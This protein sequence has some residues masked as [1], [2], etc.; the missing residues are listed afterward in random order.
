MENML[1]GL[2]GQFLKGLSDIPSEIIGAFQ[3]NLHLDISNLTKLLTTVLQ[4]FDKSYICID[5]LDECDK[6]NELLS[7]LGKIISGFPRLRIFLTGRPHVRKVV[8]GHLDTSKSVEIMASEDD[9]RK[10]IIHEIDQDSKSDPD[11]M[12]ENLRQEITK[13]IVAGSQG[14]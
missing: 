5:A 6:R 12:T 13:A 10:F 9:I 1:G 7:S 11:L 2:L 3:R 8:E 4:Q 14:M